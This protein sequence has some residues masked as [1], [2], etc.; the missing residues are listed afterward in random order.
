MIFDIIT[1]AECAKWG[2]GI[3]FK[4]GQPC[5]QCAAMGSRDFFKDFLIDSTFIPV[6]IT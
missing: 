6:D 1:F 3:G 4:G 2:D 5:V